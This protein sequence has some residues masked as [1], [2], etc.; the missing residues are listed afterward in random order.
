MEEGLAETIKLDTYQKR[1]LLEDVRRLSSS[2]IIEE[3]LAS[4]DP[5]SANKVVSSLGLSEQDYL[6]G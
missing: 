2:V 5:S 3:A 6:D 4:K 1:V